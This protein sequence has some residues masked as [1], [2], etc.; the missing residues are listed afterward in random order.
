MPF[1]QIVIGPKPRRMRADRGALRQGSVDYHHMRDLGTVGKDVAQHRQQIRRDDDDTVLGFVDH[2]REMRGRQPWVERMAYKPDAHR[3]V[4]GF[5]MR[6]GVPGQR[7]DPVAE[8]QAQRAQRPRQAVAPQ[9]QGTIADPSD[10]LPGIGLYDLRIT[11]PLCGMIQELIDGQ[12][13]CLH[14]AFETRG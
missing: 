8:P 12:A 13:V 10:R 14:G 7:P 9:A 4:I 2:R 3:G 5:E 11:E 6:L 1:Q